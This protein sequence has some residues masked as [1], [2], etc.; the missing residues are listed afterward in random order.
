MEF[1]AYKMRCTACGTEFHEI[2]NEE[3]DECP[4]CRVPLHDEAST[5]EL[6]MTWNRLSVDHTTGVLMIEQTAGRGQGKKFEPSTVFVDLGG[7][8]GGKH[9]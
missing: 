5:E 8:K 3:V 1:T 7:A 2:G 9:D 4:S 6:S